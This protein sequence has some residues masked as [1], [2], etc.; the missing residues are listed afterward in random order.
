MLALVFRPD[1][2]PAQFEGRAEPRREV[3]AIPEQRV[4]IKAAHARCGHH[5]IDRG[6]PVGADDLLSLRVPDEQMPVVLIRK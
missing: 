6:Q 5:L 2:G 4:R 1:E 3:L